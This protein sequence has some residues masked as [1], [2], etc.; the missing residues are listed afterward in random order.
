MALQSDLK[1]RIERLANDFASAVVEL[2]AEII[3]EHLRGATPPAPPPPRRAARTRISADRVLR[4]VAQHPD[5]IAAPAL[6]EALALEP[7]ARMPRALARLVASGRVTQLGDG[8]RTRYVVATV[9]APKATNGANGVSGHHGATH[10]VRRGGE[11]L[12]G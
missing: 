7:A 9:A 8:E 1:A 2:T 4:L 11:L 12:F 5:G 6:R 10:A 3:A